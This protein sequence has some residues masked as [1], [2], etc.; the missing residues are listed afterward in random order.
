MSIN[1]REDYLAYIADA[2]GSVITDHLYFGR[3]LQVP[4]GTYTADWDAMQ[5]DSV[6]FVGTRGRDTLIGGGGE[7]FTFF[8]GTKGDDLYG[9]ELFTNA[10]VDYSEARR[11]VFVDMTYRGSRTFTDESGATRTEAIIGRAQD[12]FGGTDYFLEQQ[13]PG[14]EGYGSILGIFGSSRRDVMIADAGGFGDFY[15]GGGDDLLIGG[16]SHGGA[17]NDRIIGRATGDFQ[18][19]ALGD[20][21]NDV[22]RG[23]DFQDFRFTG[24]EGNDRIF[25]MG[26]NDGYV[27]GEAGNDYIDG[28]AGDDFIDGG[29]GADVLLSGSGNDIINPDIEYYQI[30]ST[31]P[32]DGARDVIRVTR[33]DLGAYRDRVLFN[34]F[35][36]DR[37]QIRFSDAVRGGKDFRVYQED[38]ATN[39]GRV[40]TVLQI[41]GNGDG[42]G[43]DAPDDSDYFLVAQGADLS[44]HHG[45]LL[46]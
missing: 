29:V 24:G 27:I 21:G 37:D 18:F 17:G 39:P 11:G 22:L 1:N 36:E 32:R 23:T 41:D 25:A 8:L 12:G 45:Y 3:N 28:G 5:F 10:Y 31:Q 38:N 44:L 7:T 15:G 42:F 13:E 40:N 43:E 16:F 26:G 4:P 14:L 9:T 33:A 46:T 2:D 20:E 34:T 6:T 19:A 30:D 35:E